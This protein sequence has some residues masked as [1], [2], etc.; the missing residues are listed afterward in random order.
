MFVG[1]RRGVMK[2]I[3]KK[4]TEISACLYADEHNLVE[5]KNIQRIAEAVSL[6]RRK[7]TKAQRV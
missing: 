2:G 5:T 6:S 7:E 1:W 4:M 3:F